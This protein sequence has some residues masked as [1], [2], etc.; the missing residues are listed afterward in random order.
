LNSRKTLIEINMKNTFLVYANNLRRFYN[1][2][3]SSFLSFPYLIG[4][5]RRM[6]MDY[7][8]KPDNENHWNRVHYE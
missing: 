1:I 5:S 6:G 7:P 8:V 4:E 3:S 2:L